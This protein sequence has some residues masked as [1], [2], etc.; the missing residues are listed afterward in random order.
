VSELRLQ[1]DYNLARMGFDPHRRI[2]RRRMTRRGDIM[3]LALFV[4]L[5]AGALTWAFLGR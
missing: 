4:L 5:V 1:G 3:F 2:R